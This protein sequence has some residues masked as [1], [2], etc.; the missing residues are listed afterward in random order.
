MT[1]KNQEYYIASV[2]CYQVK[3]ISGSIL[4]KEGTIKWLGMSGGYPQ[5]TSKGDAM[6]WDSKE[7]IL[8]QHHEWDGMPWY[9]RLKIY[10][11]HRTIVNSVQEVEKPL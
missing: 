8:A 9:C 5:C 1:T 4:T 6:H 11:V 3:A 10:H 7:E 2:E